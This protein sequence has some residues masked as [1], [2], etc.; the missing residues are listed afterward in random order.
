M[1][2]A[3]FIISAFSPSAD[4]GAKFALTEST[5]S[6]TTKTVTQQGLS[7]MTEE[8]TSYQSQWKFEAAIPFSAAEWAQMGQDG[9]VSVKLG[10]QL[11]EKKISA[12]DGFNPKSNS[13]TFK[14]TRPVGVFSGYKYLTLPTDKPAPPAPAP[15][16]RVVYGQ[17]SLE[18]KDATLKITFSTAGKSGLSLA[19]ESF[20]AVGDGSFEGKLPCEL[21]AGNQH[22]ESEL[23]ISGTAKHRDTLKDDPMGTT[24]VGRTVQLSLTGKA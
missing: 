12:S 8:S 23:K 15:G 6:D 22:L 13:F 1:L 14:L 10:K 2:Q 11:I 4:P 24:V 16:T 18:F 7:S 19:G 9:T 17:G 3:I 5:R 21:T 20:V